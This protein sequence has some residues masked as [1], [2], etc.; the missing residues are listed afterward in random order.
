ME[1]LR[2]YWGGMLERGAVTFWEEFD[3]AITGPEQYDMYGDKFGKSLCHAW[4]ASPIYLLSKYF[5]GLRQSGAGFILAPQLKYFSSLD[6][7]LPIGSGD[8]F[9]RVSWDGKTLGV[10]TNRQ[11]GIVQLE[12]QQHR[13]APNKLWQYSNEV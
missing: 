10:E 9:I 3:P 11:G 5:V 13:L 4:S 12:N 8:G 7:T 6:C 2:T 1:R